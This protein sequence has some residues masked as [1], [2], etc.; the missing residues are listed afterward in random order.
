MSLEYLSDDELSGRAERR[1]RR[2][3]RKSKRATRKAQRR[4]RR[5][6]T[7]RGKERR[8]MRRTQR[9]TRK[10][11]HRKRVGRRATG[12]TRRMQSGRPSRIARIGLAPARGAFHSAVRLNVGKTAS[13]LVRIYNK[14]GGKE[15]LKE[16]WRK[17]GGKWGSLAKSMSK[18]GKAS[19]SDD[20][21]GAV[22]LAA[23]AAV[24]APIMLALVPIVR[25]FKAGGSPA[26][27]AAY[28]EV[29]EMGK[30]ELATNPAYEKGTAYMNDE[31]VA[32]M[33][34]NGYN[35]EDDDGIP[36]GGMM[37][38]FF[39]LGGLLFKSLFM[40]AFLP[41]MNTPLTILFAVVSTY[42]VLGIV[43]LPFHLSGKK[44]FDWYY[45]P[46]NWLLYGVTKL[47]KN[48]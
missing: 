19:I 20:E 33:D 4:T 46:I 27:E 32:V 3:S 1:A 13:K 45:Q 12:K 24:A 10:D 31:E 23:V 29:L 44:W 18:G 7:S 16:F 22:T 47:V 21:L 37:G 39:S 42:L 41:T 35:Y 6:T 43:F 38:S 5:D 11:T 15:K 30:E 28:D 2:A 34:R 40:V 14:P 17:F 26:E 9:T 36:R 48:G 8:Q 25:A